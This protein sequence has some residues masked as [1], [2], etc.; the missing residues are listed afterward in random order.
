MVKKAKLK[1]YEI[2]LKYVGKGKRPAYTHSDYGFGV[3]PPIV[4]RART[5]KGALKKLKLPSTVKV[6]RIKKV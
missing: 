1:E 3:N 4:I 5:K 6:R 2:Y